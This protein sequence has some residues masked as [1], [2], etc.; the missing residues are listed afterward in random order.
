MTTSDRKRIARELAAGLR[1]TLLKN[2]GL[3]PDNWTGLHIRAFAEIV[4][5]RNNDHPAVK[6]AG[7]KMRKSNAFWKLDY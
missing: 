2:A 5:R 6:A 7:R 3:M 4:I 1:A